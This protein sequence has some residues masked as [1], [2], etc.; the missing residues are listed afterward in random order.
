[1]P[2]V[3]D[4]RTTAERRAYFREYRAKKRKQEASAAEVAEARQAY[5]R[6]AKAKAAD[7]AAQRAL[8]REAK[9]GYRQ[10]L[11]ETEAWEGASL[12]RY[13]GTVVTPRTKYLEVIDPL[14]SLADLTPRA[15]SRVFLLAVR[16]KAKADLALLFA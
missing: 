12:R 6:E 13:P 14:F 15:A 11:R 9:A 16:R 5:D 7:Q 10:R 3:I 8:W 1:M 4:K 2:A